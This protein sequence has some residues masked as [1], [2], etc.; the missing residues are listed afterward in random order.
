MAK[1]GHI[2]W[3]RGKKGIHLSPKS[4]FKKGFTPWNKG[5]KGLQIAWN[6][7][8]RGVIKPNS[9][10]FQKDSMPWNKNKK[11]I[12]LSRKSE[13]KKGQIPANFKGWKISSQG[14]YLV[15]APDHPFANRQK[16]VLRS[17]LVMEKHIGRYLLPEEIVH[18]KGIRYPVGNIKN[19]QDDRLCNL[20]LFP[21]Q[22]AHMKVH[23]NHIS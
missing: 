10:S 17:R 14:Y 13:F 5:V 21:D 9:G 3:N 11:G 2:P 7:G 12:H 15:Y 16:Y 18:H 8:T 19:K 4:E 1:K 22:V 6:K 23:K 20:K